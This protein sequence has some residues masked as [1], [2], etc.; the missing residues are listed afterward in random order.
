MNEFYK[1][2]NSQTLYYRSPYDFK[3]INTENKLRILY[4]TSISLRNK[5]TD[6]TQFINSTKLHYTTEKKCGIWERI[7]CCHL[8]S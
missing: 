2:I 4:F 7:W 5:Y 3:N 6:I 1:T 8:H